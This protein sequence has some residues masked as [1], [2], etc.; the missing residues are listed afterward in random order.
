MYRALAFKIFVFSALSLALAVFGGSR[1]W[2]AAERPGV[3]I[4]L[5]E[6]LQ[7]DFVPE[8]GFFL[9]E[10]EGGGLQR[11][12]AVIVPLFR[13]EAQE[14]GSEPG[15]PGRFLAGARVVASAAEGRLQYSLILVGKSERYAFVG[16]KE[17]ALGASFAAD[18]LDLVDNLRQQLLR[19]KENLRSLEVQIRTQEE[20]LGRLRADADVI[21]DLGRIVEVKEEI[22]KLNEESVGLDKDIQTLERFLKLA[23]SGRSPKNFALRESQLTKQLAELAEAAKA[24]ESGEIRRRSQ[25]EQ[26]LQRKLGLVEAT[27]N[28][29]YEE[30]QRTLIHLRKKRLEIER[31]P[32]I[33]SAVP[34]VEGPE[35]YVR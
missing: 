31:L 32:V 29:D 8:E 30:L 6:A 13:T 17:M 10:F 23:L 24:A 9:V 35:D 22:N 27:R 11:V 20:S 5:K 1:A 15:L 18:T 26:E 16:P 12:K 14:K 28:E 25:S 7:L 19:R 33:R 4:V 2:S 21:G 3:V 34:H